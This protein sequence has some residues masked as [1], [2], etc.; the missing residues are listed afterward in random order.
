MAAA[1]ILNLTHRVDNKVT[2]VGNQVTCVGNQVAGVG[3]QLK[4]VD[5]KMGVVMQGMPRVEHSFTIHPILLAPMSARWKG[6]EGDTPANV[7]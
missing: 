7:K 2:D 4:D 6:C 1:Q 5:D 3:N